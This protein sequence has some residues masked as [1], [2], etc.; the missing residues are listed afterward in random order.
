MATHSS[1]L[2]GKYHGQRNLA[3][4]SPWCHKELATTERLSTY[5]IMGVKLWKAVKHYRIQRIIQLKEGKMQKNKIKNTP[6]MGLLLEASEEKDRICFI[7]ISYGTHWAP[8]FLPPFF[9]LP[10]LIAYL[11]LCAQS[12]S[13]V[14]LF[15]TA[16]TVARQAPFSMGILQARVLE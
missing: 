14:Q 2:P 15:V 5:E 6:Q 12:L 16:W 9:S 4:Y 10:E 8:C 3:G 11:F 1:I 7:N 13:C